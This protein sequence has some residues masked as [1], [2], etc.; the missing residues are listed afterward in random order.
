MS[1]FGLLV[2]GSIFCGIGKEASWSYGFVGK[3]M[4]VMGL[5][6][7]TLTWNLRGVHDTQDIITRAIRGRCLDV[8]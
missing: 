1:T 8:R 3:T 4:Q 2:M 5:F 7:K 6:T